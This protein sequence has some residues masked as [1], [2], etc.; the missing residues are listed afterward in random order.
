MKQFD[1]VLTDD[2]CCQYIRPALEEGRRCYECIQMVELPEDK[3]GVAY[4]IIDLSEYSQEE[5]WQIIDAYYD[6]HERVGLTDLIMAECAFETF[7]LENINKVF[8]SR[9]KAEQFIKDKLWE[10]L[11]YIDDY[12][13]IRYLSVPIDSTCFDEGNIIKILQLINAAYYC[14]NDDV[15]VWAVEYEAWVSSLINRQALLANPKHLYL[16]DDDRNALWSILNKREKD[17]YLQARHYLSEK[18]LC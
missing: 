16:D 1:W 12:K 5:L 18:G 9:E 10:K 2:D 17:T 11:F 3:F 4:A 14:E 6:H 7:A 8:D 15:S 13:G